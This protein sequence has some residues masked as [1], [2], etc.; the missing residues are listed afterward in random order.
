M[1]RGSVIVYIGHSL[2][3][4]SISMGYIERVLENH[5]IFA[6]RKQYFGTHDE[7]LPQELMEI[8]STEREVYIFCE[9]E[10]YPILN[11]IVATL[12]HEAIVSDGERLY[13]S[14]ASRI[15]DTGYSIMVGRCS[16]Y[17]TNISYDRAIYFPK[18]SLDTRR[19]VYIFANTRTKYEDIAESV[20]LKLGLPLPSKITPTMYMTTIDEP[21]S[22]Y[23]LEEYFG[24]GHYIVTKNIFTLLIEYLGSCGKSITFAESCTG[25]LIASAFTSVSGASA[26]LNGS[27]VTYSNEIKDEW[28]GVRKETLARYGAVSREC[29]QEMAD[30]AMRRSGADIAIA[31][32]GIA[33]PTGAVPGKPVGTVYLCIINSGEKRVRRV[34]LLGDRVAIQERTLWCAVEMLIE[35]EKGIFDFF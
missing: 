22:L 11:R 31:V 21:G 35:S 2:C 27:F 4:D 20:T 28:L 10:S 23:K 19:K 6:K 30:G 34:F 5:G 3:Q 12:S 9:K 14:T 24:R 29:V 16:L 13:P 25:G 17:I 32:S 7:S 8:V 18:E 15:F 26:I 33:G 1:K